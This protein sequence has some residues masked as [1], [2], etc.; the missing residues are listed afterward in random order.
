M[1]P[2]EI[3]FEMLA[4]VCRAPQSDFYSVGELFPIVRP[5]YQG[6]TNKWDSETKKSIRTPYTVADEESFYV[7]KNN[8]ANSRVLAVAHLDTVVQTEDNWTFEKARLGRNGAKENR[9]WNAQLDDRLGVYILLHLLPKY[10]GSE[11]F[12]VLLTTDEES[13]QSTAE[14][15]VPPTDKTYNWIF[16]FDRRGTGAVL[17]GY[18]DRDWR[19]IVD[20]FMR[21]QT[22][23]FSDICKLYHMG[24]KGLNVGT[25]YHDEH[26]D[27]CYMVEGEVLAQVA[28]FIGFF[29][30]HKD[31]HFPH[32]PNVK[33]YRYYGAG[34]AGR[35]DDWDD[36]S[37]WNGRSDHYDGMTTNSST[38]NR[39]KGGETRFPPTTASPL[40]TGRVRTSDTDGNDEDEDG[41]MSFWPGERDFEDKTD[42]EAFSQI[43]ARSM[44]QYDEQGNYTSL[45]PDGSQG[46][47]TTYNVDLVSSKD[48]MSHYPPDWW[49]LPEVRKFDLLL[50]FYNQEG[51]PIRNPALLPIY[52]NPFHEQ[53]ATAC[54]SCS[55]MIDYNEAFWTQDC[56]PICSDCVSIL[57]SGT[58]LE[59]RIPNVVTETE[60]VSYCIPLSES[61]KR[62]VVEGGGL[63]VAKTVIRSYT[64]VPVEIPRTF[65][66]LCLNAEW[67][68]KLLVF[69][70]PG[71][72][73]Y[74]EAK[75]CRDCF[76][77]YQEDEDKDVPF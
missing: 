73:V 64:G 20:E 21:V 55:L 46:K 39:P 38:I 7:F 49:Q 70:N 65:C 14:Y 58:V 12:D 72:E 19:T 9:L 62:W 67:S 50:A 31:T 40:L 1:K 47:M 23:S 34:G 30:A 37:F 44:G 43:L 10:L 51:L 75:L 41:D 60:D 32:N 59:T 4:Q 57:P 15:F 26:S 5:G 27:E 35:Y 63:R 29:F 2:I 54:K 69:K 71:F 18:E 28:D 76:H 56:M 25:G 24:V 61:N 6:W 66:D 16:Q 13:G 48:F 33:S 11:A 36:E 53:L 45:L 3:D 77:L 68:D 52:Q 8:G 42:T 17:Y 74:G 22:G